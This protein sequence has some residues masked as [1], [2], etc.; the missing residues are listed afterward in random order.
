MTLEKEAAHITSLPEGRGSGKAV[1]R[2]NWATAWASGSKQG[3]WNA[4][5][6]G[7]ES[8]NPLL[9]SFQW[10]Q[11]KL[12][13]KNH[14]LTV[15]EFTVCKPKFITGRGVFC[16][17]LPQVDY[18]LNKKNQKWSDHLGHFQDN[19]SRLNLIITDTIR[20][21]NSLFKGRS[22]AQMMAHFLQIRFNIQSN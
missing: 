10:S 21:D 8:P 19:S 3:P 7:T 15:A 4:K 17:S 12:C 6:T 5:L 2:K 16:L 22:N 20:T 13:C 9:P 1:P 14:S 11:N 18:I